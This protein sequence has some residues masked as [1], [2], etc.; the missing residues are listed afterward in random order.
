MSGYVVY[1][2]YINTFFFVSG[3]N[4]G[5]VKISRGDEGHGLKKFEYHRFL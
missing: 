1:L 4:L 2:K 3:N 5:E